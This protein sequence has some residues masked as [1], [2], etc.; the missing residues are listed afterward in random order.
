[1]SPSILTHRSIRIVSPDVSAG[2]ADRASA[3]VI[4]EPR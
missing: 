2:A 1:M 4:V 3:R